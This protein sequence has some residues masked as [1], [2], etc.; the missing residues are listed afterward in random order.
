MSAAPHLI[1][2]DFTL[3]GNVFPFEPTAA[4]ALFLR[5][6]SRGCRKGWVGLWQ[7][8]DRYGIR[9]KRVSDR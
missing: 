2:A 4:G 8:R 6:K 3:A 1:A 7:P 5:T 9:R